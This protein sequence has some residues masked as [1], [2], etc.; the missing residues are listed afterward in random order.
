M[1]SQPIISEH[2]IATP[3]V[4]QPDTPA[5]ANSATDPG[6]IQ[7]DE[8]KETRIGGAEVAHITSLHPHV[9]VKCRASVA[10]ISQ[11]GM[12]LITDIR[13][14]RG[15]LL[16]VVLDSVVV[17]GE[18]EHCSPIAVDSES[19]KVGI[20]IETVIFRNESPSH[21]HLSPRALWA[22]LTMGFQK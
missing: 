11:G 3:F 16:K 5:G 1:S 7:R 8:R 18:V 21:R 22:A 6:G 20:E 19:F 17:F 10:G 14:P 2:L 4:G 9:P 15:V 13:I 12:D